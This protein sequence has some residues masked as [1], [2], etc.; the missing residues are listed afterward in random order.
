MKKKD[1][2]QNIKPN[3]MITPE[4]QAIIDKITLKPIGDRLLVFPDTP[5]QMTASGLFIP[6]T[7]KEKPQTGWVVAVGNGK[8]M[9]GVIMHYLK[10]IVRHWQIDIH[11]KEET[12]II[13]KVGDHIMYG[14]YSGVEIEHN[15]IKVLIMRESEV[16]CFL[17]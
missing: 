2:N 12:P 11:K 3:F 13:F 9:D 8:P 6:D 1:V 5:E 16:A 4:L 7:A 10:A 15:D 14:R 17:D